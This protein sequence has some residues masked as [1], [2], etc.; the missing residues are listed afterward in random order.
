MLKQIKVAFTGPES[1]G[2]TTLANLI[3]EFYTT[4]FISE[5]AREFL[6]DKKNYSQE[7]LDTIAKKQVALCKGS[8]NPLLISDT[9]MSV[10]YIWS[11]EK[12]KN[13]SPTIQ[14][15]LEE[16]NFDH[17]FLCAPDIPWEKDELRENPFDRQRLF[18][19]YKD[20][21][22][23]KRIPFSVIK[24][25]LNTRF[26]ACKTQIETLKAEKIQL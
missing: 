10:M 22:V 7:D 26:L 17:L 21:L 13:V 15:L 20:L 3:A 12:F 25:E 4:S 14:L 2:K 5:Y 1:S 8:L 18:E 24:G 19:L 9:E 6:K 11:L 23:K 16:Q